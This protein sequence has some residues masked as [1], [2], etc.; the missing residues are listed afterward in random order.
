MQRRP[1]LGKELRTDGYYYSNIVN[2]KYSKYIFIGIFYK[3][4]VCYN[5]ASRDI[6]KGENIPELLKN[7][8]R[9]I[10][11]N[12]D[13]IKSVC[14][15]GDKIGIF[16][17]NYPTLEMETLESS[18]FPTFKHYGEILNDSTFVLHRTVNS[19]KG[20][21]VY[22]NLTYKFKKFSP[23]PDSTCVYIK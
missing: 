5:L 12:A 9:E 18:V 13:Y 23:K 10:L 8:E 14:S 15:K 22:E 19:K 20:N 3:N 1:Y 7:L 16:Q 21:V 17:V 4:G 11:L 2:Q 6:G